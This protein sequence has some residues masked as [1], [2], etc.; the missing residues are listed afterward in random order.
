MVQFTG[1]LDACSATQIEGDL[2]S[3]LGPERSCIVLDL[4]GVS[5]IDS[6]GIRLLMQIVARRK[7]GS[8]V[9]VVNPGTGGARRALEIVGLRKVVRI[10]ETLDAAL[11]R[12]GCRR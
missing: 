8:E 6:S 4:S 11:S 1:E 7:T 3:Q 10:E 9:T 5:F 12:A 2:L